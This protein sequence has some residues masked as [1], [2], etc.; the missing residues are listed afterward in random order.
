MKGAFKH[1][2]FAQRVATVQRRN[3]SISEPT[4]MHSNAA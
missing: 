2:G 1:N 4:G 3:V